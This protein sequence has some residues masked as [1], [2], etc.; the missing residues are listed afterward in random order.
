[1][2]E[3]PGEVRKRFFQALYKKGCLHN[4][5]QK[6]TDPTLHTNFAL[7]KWKIWVENKHE[8]WL[9]LY[10][11]IFKKVNRLIDNMNNSCRRDDCF[12]WKY[13][14]SIVSGRNDLVWFIHV[15]HVMRAFHC[16]GALD[17]PV[18]QV[19]VDQKGLRLHCLRR[20]SRYLTVAL[21]TLKNRENQRNEDYFIGF[22]VFCCGFVCHRWMQKNRNWQ[23]KRS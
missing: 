18:W 20:W 8:L 23:G 10:S 9:Q 6:L 11:F 12:R 1:M 21:W 22:A 15:L 19:T 16:D 3:I 5:C 4:I 17:K 7:L 13:L 14:V 2:C